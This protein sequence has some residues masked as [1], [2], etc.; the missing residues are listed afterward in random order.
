MK[1]Y[2]YKTATGNVAIKLDE[3]WCDILNAEDHYEYNQNR[4]HIRN[5]HKYAPGEPVLIGDE[6]S[7]EDW[8]LFCEDATLKA[9]E[10]NVDLEMALNTLSSMQRKYFV[11]NRMWGYSMR[12]IAHSEGKSHVA[13]LGSIAR[14]KK[15]IKLFLK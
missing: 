4:R 13:I 14:A 9:V 15:K 10:L 1:S 5:D 3:Y 2:I 7:A 8:L 6:E 11:L 12:E